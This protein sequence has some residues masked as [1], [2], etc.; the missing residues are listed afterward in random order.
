M[1]EKNHSCGL[2]GSNPGLLRIARKSTKTTPLTIR[3][4]RTCLAWCELP[5][6]DIATV[7]WLTTGPVEARVCMYPADRP[8]SV[9]TSCAC[10]HITRKCSDR[11]TVFSF[12]GWQYFSVLWTLAHI[13]QIP[14]F[15]NSKRTMKQFDSRLVETDTAFATD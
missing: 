2:Q 7:Q 13:P 14:I 12:D 15:L 3:P 5:F 11:I 1:V 9:P 8:K 10:T 4:R 6:G